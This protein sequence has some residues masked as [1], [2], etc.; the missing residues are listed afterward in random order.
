MNG[1]QS[2][3]PIQAEGDA[4]GEFDPETLRDRWI[5]VDCSG[6]EVQEMLPGC[7][8]GNPRYDGLLR[9]GASASLAPRP[10]SGPAYLCIHLAIDS[11]SAD[12]IFR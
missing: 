4:G 8:S 10:T 3:E 11:E 12:L 1:Y 7:G 2:S 9:C 5:A 6:M